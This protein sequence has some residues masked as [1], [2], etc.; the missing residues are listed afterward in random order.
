MSTCPPVSQHVPPQTIY[1]S[2]ILSTCLQLCLSID[3]PDCLQAACLH[4]H[5]SLCLY[6]FVYGCISLSICLMIIWLF[7]HNDCLVT[8]NHFKESNDE[9]WDHANSFG[10][11]LFVLIYVLN[12]S[13]LVYLRVLNHHRNQVSFEFTQFIIWFFNTDPQPPNPP[14]PT[15]SNIVGDLLC[16]VCLKLLDRWPELMKSRTQM[17]EMLSA[18]H[19]TSNRK[20]DSNSNSELSSK[21]NS[22]F[23]NTK[24]YRT[25]SAY[26]YNCK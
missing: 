13:N 11:K 8:C 20:C 15:F 2:T 4:F 23:G 21:Y 7:A 26:I 9:K 10:G 16:P 24:S 25:G 3:Q 18:I 14:T 6:K 5:Q 22:K 17:H 19:T 1:V 12:F